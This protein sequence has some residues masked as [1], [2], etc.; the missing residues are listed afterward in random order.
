LAGWL[1][2]KWVTPHRIS[3]PVICIGNVVAGG[4]GKTPVALAVAELLKNTS[5]QPHFLSRGY[6][7]KPQSK[8]ILVTSAHR[9]FEVGDEPILLA[10]SAPCWVSVN[11]IASA[12]AATAAGASHLIMDDGLQNPAL[13]KNVSLLVIDGATGI[14][15]NRVIPAGALRE[16]LAM[17]LAKTDAVV[18]VGENKTNFTTNQP[19]FSGK[20]VPLGLEISSSPI[21]AFAGIGRPEKFFSMLSEYGAQL[22]HTKAYPD[23]YYYTAQDIASLR[24]LNLPLLTTAK[25]AVKLPADFLREVIIVDI[26]FQFDQPE[27]FA[28]WLTKKLS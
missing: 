13:K 6:G 11:R 2:G 25:D 9:A 28:A 15:N 14:S 1:R 8:P 26:K 17:A 7:G 10:R 4:A 18:M 24:A 19:H 23:H 3:K 22:T 5:Q 12:Q 16:P 27:E 21:A 20:I